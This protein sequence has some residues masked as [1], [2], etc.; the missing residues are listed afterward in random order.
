MELV[1]H[2]DYQH[3]KVAGQPGRRT[4][5]ADSAPR[6]DQLAGTQNTQIWTVSILITIKAELVQNESSLQLVSRVTPGFLGCGFWC[7][8]SR[9]WG[10]GS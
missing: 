10:G 9:G 8:G 7:R 6:P 5:Y 2:T 1:R 3:Q 4:R